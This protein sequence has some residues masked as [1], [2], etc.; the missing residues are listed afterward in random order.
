MPPSD[1]LLLDQ[2]Q[3]ILMSNRQ[4]GGYTIPCQGL[5]PF[6]WNW[7]SGFI[8]LGYAHFNIEAA[9]SEIKTLLDAQWSNGFIPH[10]VFQQPSDTYFYND[11]H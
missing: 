6:Q 8:A 9:V 2:A 1:S 4:A 5:Y 3:Q 7:D 11:G 10:I